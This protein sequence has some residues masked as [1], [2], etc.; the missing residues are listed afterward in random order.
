MCD[1]PPPYKY[2]TELNSKIKLSLAK[3]SGED[4]GNE[5][6]RKWFI[7]NF[8]K[9]N[10]QLLKVDDEYYYFFI[11][12]FKCN[13]KY[14]TDIYEKPCINVSFFNNLGFEIYNDV[15]RLI[16]TL[17]IVS[18]K[19]LNAMKLLKTHIF[20]RMVDEIINGSMIRETFFSFNKNTFTDDII[21]QM[22]KKLEK[23]NTIL[24]Y[25]FLKS[26]YGDKYKWILCPIIQSQL[27]EHDIFIDGYRISKR[28][29]NLKI[30][31][32]SMTNSFYPTFSLKYIRSDKY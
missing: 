24:E 23:D 4:Y 11:L 6:R 1:K 21:L 31:K 3:K 15:S 29:I 32:T 12:F 27:K 9:H 7:D 14:I 18:V 30:V 20:C 22:V 28:V 13:T 17:P 19:Y 8:K 5:C 25:D 2:S 16:D 26:R 10:I